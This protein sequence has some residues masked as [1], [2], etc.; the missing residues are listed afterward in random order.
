MFLPQTPIAFVSY[1]VKKTNI[2]HMIILDFK[3]ISSLN[4]GSV[5]L[6]SQCGKAYAVE[7]RETK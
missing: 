1:S 6:W 4:M 5:L 2:S 3:K 7:N